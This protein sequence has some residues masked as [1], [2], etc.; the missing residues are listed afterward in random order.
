VPRFAVNQRTTPHNDMAQD[1]AQCVAVG[2]TGLGLDEAK[3]G[4]E[5]RDLDLIR[6]AGLTV[7]YV[8]PRVWPILASPLDD[9]TASQET[10]ARTDSICASIERLS[11]FEPIGIVVGGGR[12]GDPEHPAGPAEEIAP[13]L[14]QIADTAAEF[15]LR[16]GFELLGKSR[17]APFHT[18]SDVLALLDEVG[19]PNVGVIIDVIHCWP[20]PDIH[21]DL[22]R[23][24]DRVEYVQVNDARDPERTWCDRLLPGDGRGVAGGIIAALL[25]GGYRGW[26]ELE[27]FS[28]DG[29]F[30]TALPDSLWH[31][32][33][34]QLLR[35]GKIAFERL[36][37]E[38]ALLTTVGGGS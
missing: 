24:A 4:D 13:A 31:R 25:A 9:P 26:W 29:T 20:E 35:D 3:I 5:S 30:G 10:Q 28:D 27:V 7:T 15:G 6:S 23:H 19:C 18:L 12:S 37:R 33:H 16:V 22:Q 1:V 38:A 34:E 8:T 11:A 17:G 2:A 21:A 36:Y 14:A 32:P